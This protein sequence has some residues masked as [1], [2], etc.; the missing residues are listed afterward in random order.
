MGLRRS[1][2]P[3]AV[4]AALAALLLLGLGAAGELAIRR[5]AADREAR[6][7]S[8]AVTYAEVVDLAQRLHADPD[9][10]FRRLRDAGVTAVLAKEQGHHLEGA[11]VLTRRELAALAAAAPPLARL[12]AWLGDR[13]YLE[14]VLVTSSPERARALEALLRAKGVTPEPWAGEG[15]LVG[16]GTPLTPSGLDRVGLGPPL[17]LLRALENDL[18]LDTYV[19]LK[20][21]EDESAPLAP[22]LKP[23]AGL[24]RLRAVFFNDKDLPG[25]P[26]RLPELARSLGALGV[27]V[28]VIEGYAQQGLP[29]LV[30]AVD[31]RAVRLHAIREDELRKLPLDRA[32]ERYRLAA[33]ERGI[34]VLLLR[35]VPDESPAAA[36]D[37]T[38]RL[39]TD[40]RRALAEEGFAF[41]PPSPPRA[42]PPSP[43]AR[44][45]LVLGLAA[46]AALAGHLAGLAHLGAL[47]ALALLAVEGGLLGSGHAYL[48]QKLGASATALVFPVLAA[49]C[50]LRPQP[51]RPVAAAAGVAGAAAVAVAGGLLELAFQAH[52]HFLL[53]TDVPPG[54][55]LAAVLPP[56][57]VAVLAAWRHLPGAFA[58]VR[59]GLRRWRA[60]RVPVSWMV[61]AALG[62]LAAVVYVSRTGNQ[63]LV[64]P[65]ELERAARQWLDHALGVRPRFK[66]FLFGYPLLLLALA[67]GVR[68]PLD[69]LLAGAGTVA[70][71]SVVNTFSHA[72]TPVAVSL[73]RTLH[74]LWLGT[75]AGLVL[76]AVL[77]A[78][79]RRVGRPPTQQEG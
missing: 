45:A 17:D 25:W 1:T 7:V 64:A 46:A 56:A 9:D 33:A 35:V 37:A 34:R 38:L 69:A 27:P 58:G 4:T 29:Q 78:W 20:D 42:E 62:V 18:G 72:H 70:L 2:F 32:V 30:E 10:L 55:K 66:E 63:P 71:A 16:L 19:Q 12:E 44:W 51:R 31:G 43:A 15:G 47:A 23:L 36:L 75:L 65:P 53:R 21:R 11:A 61:L 52:Y 24:G 67:R 60:W 41:G 74:G 6:C 59:T 73:L 22:L 57:A 50:C 28:G 48:A 3:R 14:T 79:A 39:A 26:D 77:A 13:P 40:V 76:W 8:V 54:T 49:L 68:G 5:H